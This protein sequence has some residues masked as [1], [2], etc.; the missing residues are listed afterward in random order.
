MYKEAFQQAGRPKAKPAVSIIEK[1]NALAFNGP[2]GN[3]AYFKSLLGTEEGFTVVLPPGASTPTLVD[4]SGWANVEVTTPSPF[5]TLPASFRTSASTTT[6]SVIDQLEFFY[7]NATSQYDTIL[8]A[9]RDYI[10]IKVQEFKTIVGNVSGLAVTLSSDAAT[11]AGY[12]YDTDI[13]GSTP[14]G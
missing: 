12:S 4:M 8:N 9:V 10:W 1:L 5:P 13:S 7:T 6:N 14:D 3:K 11:V 2:A